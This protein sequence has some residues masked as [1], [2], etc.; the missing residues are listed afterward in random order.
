VRIL[1]H[2]RIASRD[3]QYVHVAELTRALRAQGH[4]IIMVAPALGGGESFGGGSRVVAGLKRAVP[5]ALYEL[6]EFGY[7]FIA[8]ARL[9][10]A[11][12][13]HRPDF[14]YERYNLH[15]PA[16]VWASRLLRLPLLLEV[17]SPLYHER[18]RFDGIALP[19][20]AQ[21]SE[22]Y[23]W[24]GAD[25]VLPV[26][27][28]LA[29]MVADRGVARERITVLHNGIAWEEFR[30]IPERTSA[31]R[32]LG[33]EGRTVLGFTGFVRSWHGI[34]SVLPLLAVADRHLLVVGDGPARSEIEQAARSAG[35]A[36]RLTF[37]GVVPRERIAAHVAAFDIALQPDVV[38][39]A[40]P[41]KLF[42]Y[43]ALGRAI[44]APDKANLRE[45]LTDGENALLFPSGDREAFQRAIEKLC[46][47]PALRR[48]LAENARATI[49]R[50]GL[51]WENNARRVTDLAGRLVA[52]RE[53]R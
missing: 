35:V 1:Y 22:G 32:A 42:E 17:N 49:T 50:R 23:S 36:E 4:E 2:H 16:G 20:L 34:E 30:R 12:L 47:A 31:K 43:L 53:A 45:I 44:V 52:E 51:T 27:G 24:R 28:V 26:T 10:A 38:D 37:T 21:W 19:R 11:G 29:A 5:G 6:L 3:G 14:I 7:S 39:Y 33:L 9:L 46:A 48:R 13:W 41:L 25:R 18:A 8:L 40:S 15:L